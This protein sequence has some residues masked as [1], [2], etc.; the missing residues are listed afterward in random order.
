VE[1]IIYSTRASALKATG[2]LGS[3]IGGLLLDAIRFP[4]GAQPGEVASEVITRL[5]IAAGPAPAML[6]LLS[7]FFFIRYRLDRAAHAE[8]AAELARRRAALAREQGEALARP[9]PAPHAAVA[10]LR[11]GPPVADPEG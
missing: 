3:M 4:T 6:T 11:F 9:E 1:G 2:G 10:D 8:I 5:G 7:L